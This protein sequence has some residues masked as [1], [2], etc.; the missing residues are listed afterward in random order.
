MPF[1]RCATGEAPRIQVGALTTEGRSF[2]LADGM[3]V[4]R[5][6]LVG[7]AVEDLWGPDDRRVVISQH[8]SFNANSPNAQLEI[9]TFAPVPSRVLQEITIE[10]RCS[11]SPSQN[12]IQ[13]TEAYNFLNQAWQVVD[14]RAPT[15]SDSSIVVRPPS[16]DQFY[17]PITNRMAIRIGWLDRGVL[18]LGWVASVDYVLWRITPNL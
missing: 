16:A 12:V 6:N 1:S 13:R 5:G 2:S 7:G 8:H 3:A 11:A 15:R 10:A 18:S 9:E 4:T 17:E 14:E